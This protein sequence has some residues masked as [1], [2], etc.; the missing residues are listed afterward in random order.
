MECMRRLLRR[1]AEAL[2]LLQLL[3]EHNLSR[4]TQS[5]KEDDRKALL[6]LTFQRLVCTPEGDRLATQ[7][8]AA[9]M[10]YYVSGVSGGGGVV[11]E[12]SVQLR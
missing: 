10:Q 8:I 4:L 11:K 1:S 12:L 7:L 6:Q 3:A 9:L 2:L 5:L